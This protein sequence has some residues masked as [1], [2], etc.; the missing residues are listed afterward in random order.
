MIELVAFDGRIATVDPHAWRATIEQLARG[1]RI[2][3]TLA[4]PLADARG[5]AVTGEQ[6]RTLA[7]ACSHEV[8]EGDHDPTDREGLRRLGEFFD[9]SG[10]FLVRPAAQQPAAST[11]TLTMP[12]WQQRLRRGLGPIGIAIIIAIKWLAKLK[13]L[14][15]AIT[16][17]KFASTALSGLAS[18]GAYALFWGWRFA[19]LFVLLLF[20]HEMGHV[21]AARRVGLPVTAPMFV[22]FLGAFIG[23]KE[24][25]KD[26]WIEAQVGLGGPLL[27]SLGA[28]G[29]WVVGEATGSNLLIAAA[30]TGFF[31]NLFNLAPL[32]PLDGGHAAAALHPYVWL[33]G[34][35]VIAGLTFYSPHVILIVILAF[36]GLETYRRL[37][38]WRRG[39][40]DARRFYKVSPGRRAIV[41]ITY[42][43]LAAAL[44]FAMAATQIPDPG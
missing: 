4:G 23:L 24:A 36:G 28:A 27:G 10:G 25:P 43:G 21:I 8:S 16:K 42:F 37:T 22:P 11:E 12:K 5:M 14:L 30:Y 39:D 2:H 41:A 6:A 34:L 40:E 15:L 19:V 33:L 26:A 44:V 1:G 9:T 35:F 3:E 31:L 29:V 38:A 7:A 32:T 20:I 13:V 17:I 18:I